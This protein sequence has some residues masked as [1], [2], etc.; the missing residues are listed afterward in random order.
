MHHDTSHVP[1]FLIYR[2]CETVAEAPN[3]EPSDLVAQIAKTNAFTVEKTV[4]EAEGLCVN[5]K[6]TW[7]MTLVEGKDI[8]VHLDGRLVLD[9]VNISVNKGEIVTLIGPNG[10]GKSTLI[11]ALSVLSWQARIA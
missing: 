6:R 8:C 2:N 3:K 5:P 9:R 4:Y 1:A 11:G 7:P 10:S